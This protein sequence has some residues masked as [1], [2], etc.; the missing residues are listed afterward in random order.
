M[1]KTTIYLPDDLDRLLK[2]QARRTGTPA[3]E[4]VRRALGES[5]RETESPLPASIGI[6]GGDSG[7]AA[8]DDEAQL[9][10]NW[11]SSDRSS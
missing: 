3:A 11:A 2:A 8:A 4:I 1:R 9:E 10:K 5:L 6:G 7:F